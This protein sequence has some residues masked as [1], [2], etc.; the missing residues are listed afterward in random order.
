MIELKFSVQIN[1]VSELEK[2]I[3]NLKTIDSLKIDEFSQLDIEINEFKERNRILSIL[4][5]TG[6][7]FDDAIFFNLI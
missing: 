4:D 7:S 5:K 6:L 3:S 2:I 1:D